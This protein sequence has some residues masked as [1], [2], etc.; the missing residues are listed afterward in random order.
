VPLNNWHAPNVIDHGDWYRKNFH[1]RGEELYVAY[2]WDSVIVDTE[3]VI[4]GFAAVY[5]AP[6]IDQSAAFLSAYQDVAGRRFERD[7]LET[8]WA[9]V[10]WLRGWKSQRQLAAGEPIRCLSKDEAIRL[11]TLAGI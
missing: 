7:E 4:V 9:A 8:T 3:A 2:D 6:K 1:W 5:V 10:L 11:S